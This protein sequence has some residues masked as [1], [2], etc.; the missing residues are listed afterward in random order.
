M[1]IAAVK[2]AAAK[3]K[4]GTKKK[5]QHKFI[6]NC[7]Q[8]VEDGIMDAANFEKYLHERIKVRHYKGDVE[9]REN[10]FVFNFESTFFSP[11]HALS[12]PPPHEF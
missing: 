4:G 10:T 9:S 3:G 8:P 2:K 7:T 5:I 1:A 6:L 11:L 12:S